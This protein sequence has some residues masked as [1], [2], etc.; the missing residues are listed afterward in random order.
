MA[1]EQDGERQDERL[2]S[3]K[4]ARLAWPRW[5]PVFL[6]GVLVSVLVN[7][8]TLAGWLFLGPWVP[9]VLNVALALVI[10]GVY[11]L[12]NRWA[13]PLGYWAVELPVAFAWIASVGLL[14]LINLG[15]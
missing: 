12:E 14:G 3:E 11:G 15:G 5:A 9:A 6:K 13:F 8:L 2:P 10:L 4:G 7:L 1:F